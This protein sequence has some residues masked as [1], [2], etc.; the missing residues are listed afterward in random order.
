MMDSDKTGDE[1]RL[2]L[3][4][5]FTTRILI[6]IGESQISV[7]GSSNDLS[8]KGVFVSSKDNIPVGTKCNI[9]VI[10][11]GMSPEVVLEMQGRVVRAVKDGFG[12]AFDSMDLDSYTHLKNI[13]K[14]NASDPDNIY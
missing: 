3:R 11:T 2:H 4:V 5:D 1:R 12:V 10:L 7:E 9:K 8:L 13:V 6:T 14:Y